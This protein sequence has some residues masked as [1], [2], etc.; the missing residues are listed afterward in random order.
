MFF[1]IKEKLADIKL[2]Y[3]QITRL[4]GKE[5]FELLADVNTRKLRDLRE[6]HFDFNDIYTEFLSH[7]SI[8]PHQ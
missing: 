1:L 2:H 4:I 7:Q 6:T 8:L 5:L 3:N